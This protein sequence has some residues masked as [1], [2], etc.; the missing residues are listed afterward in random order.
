M[1]KIVIVAAIALIG[2]IVVWRLPA[3]TEEVKDSE[4][5]RVPNSVSSVQQGPQIASATRVYFEN[6]A[7]YYVRPDDQNVYPGVIM[8]HEWW[9]L[10][11]NIKREAENLAREG[12]QVLAVDLYD[13]EVAE[14][15]DRARELSS[16]IDQARAEE[17]L[18][19]AAA[20]LRQQDAPKLAS[21]GW[22]FGGGQSLNIALSGVPFDATVIYYGRLNTNPVDLAT[23]KWPVLGIFGAEDTSIP[24]QTVGDFEAALDKAKVPNEIHIY[25]GVGHAFANPS[26]NN[27]AVE[28]TRDAWQKTL[29][30]LRNTLKQN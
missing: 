18:R 1:K 27:Y 29:T 30:F 5:A 2:L 17:N 9:G 19:A 15:P 22:C 13:G 4:G 26:G 10:N 28:E 3:N 25:D 23:I 6:T 16:G 11:E 8:I 12:Y 24:V 7:G 14:S 20:F 21:L